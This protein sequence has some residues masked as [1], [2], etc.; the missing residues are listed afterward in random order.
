VSATGKLVIF[1]APSGAG[2]TTLVRHLAANYPDKLEFS[3]SACS[4]PRREG[5]TH[6]KDYYFLSVEEFKQKIVSNEFV[7]WEQVYTNNYYGTL[8][9]EIERIWAKN[10]AVL[11]DVD[12]VGGINLKKIYGENALGIFVKAPS[13]EELERRLRTRN[14]ETEESIKRRIGKAAREM[15][16][17]TRFDKII[18][19]SD[20]EEAKRMAEQLVLKFL[21]SN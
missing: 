5:E 12:V 8:R 15:E 20:M 7:E 14:T 4:R 21:D 1:C 2:K 16:F 17:E 3:I 10:K 18:V 13:V 19:N 9:S 6:G 11:F